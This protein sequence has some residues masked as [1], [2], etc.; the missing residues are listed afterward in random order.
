M[1]AE[2]DDGDTLQAAVGDT[3]VYIDPEVAALSRDGTLLAELRSD[4]I[5]IDEPFIYPEEAYRGGW[6][7]WLIFQV[8]LDPFGE[9][10]EYE[11]KTKSPNEQI[12]F[13]AEETFASM[14]WDPT[15]I[16]LE[17]Q[18]QWLYY[19]FMVQKPDLLK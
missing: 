3:S 15:R 7:G 9:I 1:L 2:G 16:Q 8:L 18:D 12:N 6:E 17:L 19:R 10:E 4:P 14:A 5:R 13:L 11:L